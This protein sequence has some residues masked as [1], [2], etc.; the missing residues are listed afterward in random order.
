MPEK[1]YK[2]NDLPLSV[3]NDDGDIDYWKAGEERDRIESLKLSYTERFRIMMR[4][5]RMDMM[6]RKAKVTHKKFPE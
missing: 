3:V 1:E 2:I 4:L 6:L 5:M